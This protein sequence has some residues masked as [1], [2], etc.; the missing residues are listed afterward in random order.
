MFE[1]HKKLG[2]ESIRVI[3]NLQELIDSIRYDSNILL[4]NGP[5][6]CL[7]YYF[8]EFVVDEITQEETNQLIQHIL[9]MGID[10]LEDAISDN[11]DA[12]NYYFDYILEEDNSDRWE[13]DSDCD[14]WFTPKENTFVMHLEKFL[15]LYKE[16]KE[17]GKMG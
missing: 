4:M 15:K 12:I 3:F 7:G 8:S 6:G 17:N 9:D 2:I 11:P 13:V 16:G 14:H 5:R 10:E 1:E